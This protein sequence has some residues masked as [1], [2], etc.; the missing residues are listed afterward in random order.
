MKR[1]A[2]KWEVLPSNISDKG[3]VFTIYTE[4]LTMHNKKKTNLEINEGLEYTI[5]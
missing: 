2:T 1:Q 4:L 3:L 5:L